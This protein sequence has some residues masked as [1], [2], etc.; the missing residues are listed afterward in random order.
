MGLQGLDH[1]RP[2]PTPHPDSDPSPSFDLTPPLT[3]TLTLALPL[4]LTLTLTLTKVWTT[5]DK[6]ERADMTSVIHGK[7]ALPLPLTSRHAP[8]TP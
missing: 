8:R 3:P 7:Y 4:H 6:H 2:T 5:V 1:R